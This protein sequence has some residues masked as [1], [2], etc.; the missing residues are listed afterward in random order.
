[1]G[2]PRPPRLWP[3]P[4]VA[5]QAG[6]KPAGFLPSPHLLL[7]VGKENTPGKAAPLPTRVLRRVQGFERSDFRVGKAACAPQMRPINLAENKCS[8]QRKKV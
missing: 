6:E 5:T 3:L 4:P 2:V 1:M 8:H 7:P